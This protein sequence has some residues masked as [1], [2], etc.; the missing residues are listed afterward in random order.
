MVIKT[1]AAQLRARLRRAVMIIGLAATT[2]FYASDL[3]QAATVTLVDVGGA[4]GG[5]TAIAENQAAAVGFKLGS[6]YTDVSISAPLLCIDC[7]GVAYLMKGLIGP[8]SELANVIAA[9]PFDVSVSS[10]PLFSGLSLA[11]GSYFLA[12]ALLDN[13]GAVSWTGSDPETVTTVP[14]ASTGLNLFATEIDPSEPFKSTFLVI[15]SP[16]ALHLTVT[17]E[18]DK[19]DP[20]VV[21]LPTSAGFLVLGLLGLGAMRTSAQA[22]RRS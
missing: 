12:L 13:G 6:D 18:F 15:T 14:G 22:R 21:P 7:T 8:T 2:P 3:A 1:F 19:P 9:K 10:S 5:N 20:S 11:A 16:A 4:G 17:A